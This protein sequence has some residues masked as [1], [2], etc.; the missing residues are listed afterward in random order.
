MRFSTA[1]LQQCWFVA[2]P[3]AVGKTATGIELARRLNG[4]V[5]ALD[6]MSLYRR[7][8]IGTAKPDRAEQ[9]AA[10]HHLIDVI[11]P[12]E[13]YTVADYV[14]LAEQTCRQII[15]RGRTPVFVGGTGLYLR[16]VLRGV[17]EGPPADWEY[18]RQLEREMDQKGGE[19]LHGE[20]QR[21]DPKSAVRLH[22]A[23]QR[24]VIRALEV[25]RQTGRPASEL[26]QEQPLPAVERPQHVYW[27]HPP[28]DWLYGRIDR[29]VEIMIE[30][31]LRDEVQKLLLHP[32]GLSRTAQQALGYKEMIDHLEGRCSLAEAV[33]TIQRRTRQFAKRQHTWF[34]NL[35]EC[36]AV[37]VLPD[38]TAAETAE[39]MTSPPAASST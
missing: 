35:E 13:E 26:Q 3:T 21:V 38:E 2:G 39:R 27:L 37:P 36:R 22:P 19:W 28:R 17:F 6:S 11:E 30:C 34:R 32:R 14:T 12:W 8:D 15:D 1:L 20:L 10:A 9:A 7:M 5:L 18:R 23:D 29:R 4:E 25:F 24:R 31:G 33:A 16:S